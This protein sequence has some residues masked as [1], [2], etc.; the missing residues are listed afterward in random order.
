MFFLVDFNIQYG[1]ELAVFDTEGNLVGV[2][3]LEDGNNG[4]VVWA[5]DITRFYGK[6]SARGGAI[7]GDGGLVEV[8]GKDYLDFK[9]KVD[10]FAPK[11]ESGTLL[12]DPTNITISTTDANSTGFTAGTDNT[13]AFA[14]Q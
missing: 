9:G 10:L 14:D 7:K 2:S 3:V 5:D 1:D 6:I 8:S 11:G 4:V 13:E 12:L